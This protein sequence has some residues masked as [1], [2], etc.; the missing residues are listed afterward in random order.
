MDEVSFPRKRRDFD[1]ILKKNGFN[2][3]EDINEVITLLNNEEVLTYSVTS[4]MRIV[5]SNYKKAKNSLDQLNNEWW[6]KIPG[7][8]NLTSYKS[9]LQ[10]HPDLWKRQLSLRHESLCSVF[11]CSNKEPDYP[12]F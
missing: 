5:Q 10:G 3:P 12:S 4:Y 11:I 7:K 9:N 8:Q 2:I 6:T 1:Y